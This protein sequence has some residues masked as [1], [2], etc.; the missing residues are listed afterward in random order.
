MSPRDL[1]GFGRGRGLL[2]HAEAQPPASARRYAVF[3]GTGSRANL[4]WYRRAGYRPVRDL[5]APAGGP[6][7]VLGG[8]AL[9]RGD[10]AGND[11]RAGA[12]VVWLVKA[13]P[14][15]PGEADSG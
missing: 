10:G 7:A 13:R 15:A 9:E 3:T 1:R 14:R 5:D 8:P 2:A 12:T 4:A 11:T 6:R